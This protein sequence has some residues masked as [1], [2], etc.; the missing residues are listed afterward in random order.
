VNQPHKEIKAATFGAA[1]M[2]LEAHVDTG[3]VWPVVLRWGNKSARGIMIGTS[4]E[5]T[6]LL[7][8]SDELKRDA[9]E[10]ERRFVSEMVDAL[11]TKLSVLGRLRAALDELDEAASEARELGA[12]SALFD[13]LRDLAY[14]KLHPDAET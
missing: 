6:L 2:L 7:D 4:Q 8:A 14:D 3:A 13:E 5:A 11:E 12:G 9:W 1:L 10:Y